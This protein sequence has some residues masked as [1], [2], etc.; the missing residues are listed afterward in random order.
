MHVTVKC[1]SF[2]SSVCCC[3]LMLVDVPMCL[4]LWVCVFLRG[5]LILWPLIIGIRLYSYL[6]RYNIRTLSGL[7]SDFIL[8]NILNNLEKFNIYFYRMKDFLF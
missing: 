8:L 1:F 4:D 6:P 2:V 7:F 3:L 5:I